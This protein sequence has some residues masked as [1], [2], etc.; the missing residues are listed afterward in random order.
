MPPSARKG[1]TRARRAPAA[2]PQEPSDVET[3]ENIATPSRSSRKRTRPTE[4]AAPAPRNTR[5]KIKDT[6][7]L[8]REDT[9]GTEPQEQSDA[10]TESA[11]PSEAE[12]I[13]NLKVADRP[14]GVTGDFSNDRIEGKE[15]VPGYGKLAGRDWT[16]IIR[17]VEVNI[18]RPEVIQRLHPVADDTQPA[19][20]SS[21]TEV[22]ID[23]GPDRQVSRS[24]AIISYDADKMQWFIIVNGRNGLRVDNYLLKRGQQTYL[25]NG[26]VIE[27]ANTQ[28]AF[29][30]V[31][32]DPD[33]GPV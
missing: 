9:E 1:K 27:I 19:G 18:G 3:P 32:S 4:P 25:R 10:E 33:E 14:I 20:P 31:S 11:M 15:H 26:S 29:I 6:R 13:A 17:T 28:M 16:Y 5:R 30:T 12:I 2:E 21:T 23:L 8:D 7:Q 22:H 24:H